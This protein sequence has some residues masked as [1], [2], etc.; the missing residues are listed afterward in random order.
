MP[1]SVQYIT[2]TQGERI[3]VLLNMET[4]QQLT[5]LSANSE[6]LIGLTEDELQALAETSLSVK[7]QTELD[8][9]LMKNADHQ[10]SDEERETLDKLIAQIDQLN[11]L[12]T[13]ARYT[14]NQLENKSKVA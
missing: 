8:N 2:N 3:G 7:S 11:I 1:E 9:L 10:L 13:R 12:K 6:L 5:N 4:Y 14:L